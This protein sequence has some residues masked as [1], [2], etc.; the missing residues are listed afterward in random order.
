MRHSTRPA[1]AT[2]EELSRL[3]RERPAPAPALTMDGGVGEAVTAEVCA[4]R[5]ARIRYLQQKLGAERIRARSAFDERSHE[6]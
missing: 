3:M 5:Q 1:I 6:R 2:A 4:D